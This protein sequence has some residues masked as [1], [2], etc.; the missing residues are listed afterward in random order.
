MSDCKMRNADWGLP[1]SGAL[2]PCLAIRNLE[3]EAD[4]G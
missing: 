1:L 3:G 4:Y 2:A